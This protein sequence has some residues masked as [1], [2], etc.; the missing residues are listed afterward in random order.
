MCARGSFDYES[1]GGI[2]Q[3]VSSNIRSCG[4]YDRDFYY[5]RVN[6]FCLYIICILVLDACWQET[7]GQ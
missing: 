1:L 6:R 4:R 3:D 7:S 2:N 5:S